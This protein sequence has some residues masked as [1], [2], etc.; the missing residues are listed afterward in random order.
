[1]KQ[2]WTAG[3][4][5]RINKG[6]FIE[7]NGKI[8]TMF[9]ELIKRSV[10]ENQQTFDRQVLLTGRKGT[11]RCGVCMKHNLDRIC[12][13]M[14]KISNICTKITKDTDLEFVLALY[15]LTLISMAITELLFLEQ[16]PR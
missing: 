15:L 3:L 10:L 9:A 16:C 4:E 8:S 7:A 11:Y 6:T 12:T 2:I 1:M 14:C 5:C 13:D